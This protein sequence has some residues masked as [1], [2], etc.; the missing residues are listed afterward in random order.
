MFGVQSNSVMTD[1]AHTFLHYA[2]EL[3]NRSCS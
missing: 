3:D 2:E 1:S